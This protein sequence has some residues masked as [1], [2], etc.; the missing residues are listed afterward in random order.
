M[1]EIGFSETYFG[2]VCEFLCPRFLA[3]R[4]HE[5]SSL[6]KVSLA[7]GRRKL[8]GLQTELMDNFMALVHNH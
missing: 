1:T 8:K 3:S 7:S 2:R 5:R 6:S 4:S